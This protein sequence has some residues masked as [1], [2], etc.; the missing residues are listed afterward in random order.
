MAML[1]YM[2]DKVF[3]IVVLLGVAGLM[4]KNLPWPENFFTYDKLADFSRE[5]A[6]Y[7]G[8][9]FLPIGAALGGSRGA[10]NA[11][12]LW[13]PFIAL[14]LLWQP[15]DVVAV[16]SALLSF[17]ARVAHAGFRALC[18]TLLALL[19]PI[20]FAWRCL[21][22]L[23]QSVKASRSPPEGVQS[24]SPRVKTRASRPTSVPAWAPGPAPAPTWAPA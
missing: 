1:I 19:A 8:S 11:L 13:A 17:T 4:A 2:D 10:R 3:C 7:L 22:G 14:K 12:C 16:L 6:T 23:W 24:R 9:V 18:W 15:V 5:P 20:A 21:V